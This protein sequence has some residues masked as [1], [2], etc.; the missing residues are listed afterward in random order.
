MSILIFLALAIGF[1][2]LFHRIMRGVLSPSVA[3]GIVT[4]LAFHA[5]GFLVEGHFDSLVMI[6]IV[7]T[8]T[9]A[10]AIALGIGAMM[11]RAGK[12]RSSQ[13]GTPI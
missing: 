12:K 2:V 1:G 5:L 13:S 11:S 7:V 8:S 4:G 6:S 9:V 3:S 10:F